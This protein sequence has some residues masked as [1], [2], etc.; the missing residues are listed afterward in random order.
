MGLPRQDEVLFYLRESHALIARLPPDDDGMAAATAQYIAQAVKLY[1]RQ[2]LLLACWSPP[3][4]RS[5]CYMLSLVCYMLCL[6][7][8]PV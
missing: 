5:C 4:R 1:A 6:V 8:R 3:V 7:C 2:I